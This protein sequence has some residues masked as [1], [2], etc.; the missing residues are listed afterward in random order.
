MIFAIQLLFAFHHFNHSVQFT[1]QITLLKY[2]PKKIAIY[3]PNF[4]VLNVLKTNNNNLNKK[5]NFMIL[6]I[7]SKFIKELVV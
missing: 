7:E 2:V 1:K 4:V 6:L 5:D 3:L